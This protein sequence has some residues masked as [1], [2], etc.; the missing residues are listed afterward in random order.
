MKDTT[1]FGVVLTNPAHE[2]TD[3][4]T[5][6]S[7]TVAMC[8]VGALATIVD[9]YQ[10]TDGLLGIAAQGGQRFSLLGIE[11]QADGL[12]IGTVELLPVEPAIR[13]PEDY[14]SM[15]ALLRAVIE[16]LG[17]L[18]ETIDKH[19]DDATWVGYRFAE[20]LPLD[21]EEK[22]VFLELNDPLERLRALRP[23]LRQLRDE[24]TQ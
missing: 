11:Q 9:W 19:Y 16:D 5:H 2:S 3:N 24:Q 6:D 20:V 10:G 14:T 17:R 4:S 21:L 22:Q 7:T 18:Y 8:A 1:P 12:N 13:L 15:A 23:S